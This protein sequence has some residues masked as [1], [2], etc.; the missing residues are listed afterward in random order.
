VLWLLAGTVP[1]LAALLCQTFPRTG[2]AYLAGW[3]LFC[4]PC[5]FLLVVVEGLVP[6]RRAAVLSG[7]CMY[8]QHAR[9]VGRS[10]CQL[11][12]LSDMGG[13]NKFCL[14]FRTSIS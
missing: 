9:S 3:L 6:P 2:L 5:C 10:S 8:T 12:P 11:Q 14:L 1:S 4:S 13:V 7:R